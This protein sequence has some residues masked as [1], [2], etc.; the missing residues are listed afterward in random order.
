MT[1]DPMRQ[2]MAADFA[3][4]ML[5]LGIKVN[6]EGKAWEDIEPISYSEAHLWGWGSNSPIEIYNLNYSEGTS[7]FRMPR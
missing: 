1:N 5:P 7:E 6:V 3:E 2:A 4:Q